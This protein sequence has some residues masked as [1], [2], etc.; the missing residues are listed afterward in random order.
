MILSGEAVLL[1]CFELLDHQ[2]LSKHRRYR[3][4]C[5]PIEID[6]MS[7]QCAEKL[8]LYQCHIEMLDVNHPTMRSYCYASV[9]Y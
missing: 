1:T 6:K 7:T 3:L 8:I 5:T 4:N 9:W 2:T